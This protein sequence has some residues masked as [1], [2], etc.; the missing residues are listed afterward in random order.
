MIAQT[1][2]GVGAAAA[3]VGLSLMSAR[4]LRRALS[5]PAAT[6]M[7]TASE[8]ALVR[9]VADAFFP[10]G[11]PIPLS[12]CEAQIPRYFEGYLRRSQILKR[13][14][15]RLL[16]ASTELGPLAFGPRP[17]RFTRLAH[18]EQLQFLAGA[19]GSRIYFR[20]V[21]FI[22]LRALMTMAYLAKAEVA[23][24]MGM[25]HDTDPFGVG[26]RVLE[27]MPTGAGR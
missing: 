20:R 10:P 2:V 4:W 23:A 9:A 12:G 25:V 3:A 1:A 27:Q 16:L 13:V 8:R 19:S 5:A 15:I 14:L 7:L 17:A 24:H 26:G 18:A 21:S 11:G 22:S 6:A